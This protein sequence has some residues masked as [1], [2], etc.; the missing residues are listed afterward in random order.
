M[1][2]IKLR[3]IKRGTHQ[4]NNNI[5]DDIIYALV[6]GSDMPGNI[7]KFFKKFFNK[8][9]NLP[10]NFRDV[11]EISYIPCFSDAQ[12]NEHVSKKLL[13]VVSIDSPIDNNNLI[14]KIKRTLLKL[15]DKNSRDDLAFDSM[16]FILNGSNINFIKWLA[17]LKS[18]IQNIQIKKKEVSDF[19]VYIVSR[20]NI[21]NNCSNLFCPFYMFLKFSHSLNDVK[22][23][24]E[25]E[26][27]PY[28]ELIT[29]ISQCYFSEIP[30][31]L[32]HIF[33]KLRK[34]E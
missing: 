27:T 20:N 16:I 22:F 30:K 31:Y 8:S 32:I 4:M 9:I 19:V 21:Q 18:E 11:T 23:E 14:E 3:V 25:G 1:L 34:T 12:S 28:I 26:F 6:C 17:K 2:I 7:L 10:D 15:F 24:S 33:F 5:D 13:R 29:S